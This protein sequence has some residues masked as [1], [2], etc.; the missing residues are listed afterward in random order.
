[1]G[2]SAAVTAPRLVFLC[3]LLAGCP[4]FLGGAREGV[5]VLVIAP[6]PDD[7]SILAA[8]VMRQ[9]LAEGKKVAVVVMTNG[10]K[11]CDADRDGYL[12]EAETVAALGRIGLAEEAVHFLGYPDGYLDQLGEKPAG[13]VKRRDEHGACVEASTT[14]AVRGAGRA[15]EHTARTGQPAAFTARA[16]E[17]DLVALLDRLKPREVYL[18]HPLD[19]HADHRATYFWFR[20]ALDRL[21]SGPRA[22]HRALIHAPG[23]WPAVE[24]GHPYTPELPVGPLPAPYGGYVFSERVPGDAAFKLDVLSRYRSQI[25]EQPAA[26]WLA[27]FARPFEQFAPEQLVRTPGGWLRAAGPAGEAVER[28]VP[29]PG[30]LEA[31]DGGARLELE[32]GR[33]ELLLRHV[34][35]AGRSPIGLWRLEGAP[36]A[37]RLRVDPR[38]DDGEATEVT[39]RGPQG[40]I[41]E[42]VIPASFRPAAPA[43]AGPGTATGGS[44]SR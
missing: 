6:H 9:A 24:C 14:Y 3:L 28:E 32:Y 44:P 7:E 23:C 4:R 26:D 33:G 42:S 8:G 16:L 30:S 38:P 2:K 31:A 21:E 35:P 27:S 37:L 36:A 29:V 22:V 13:P 17:E 1:M 10:D 41:G 15:D 43:A 12:R 40:F 11:G 5:D 39:L 34:S 20:R 19:T 25:G 18:P